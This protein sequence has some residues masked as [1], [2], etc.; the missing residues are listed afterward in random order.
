MCRGKQC[1][2]ICTGVAAAA[3]AA[4][5]DIS[6]LEINSLVSKSSAAAVCFI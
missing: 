4:A 2:H 1:H 5:A 3:A 6:L